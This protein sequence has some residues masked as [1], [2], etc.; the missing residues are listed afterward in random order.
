MNTETLESY[1]NNRTG[2][3]IRAEWLH[4]F[5]SGGAVTLAWLI[6]KFEFVLRHE[7][8][9]NDKE[10]FMTQKELSI[11]TKT[12]ERTLYA[13]IQQLEENGVLRISKRTVP[14]KNWYSID[15]DRLNALSDEIRKDIIKGFEEYE[16]RHGK[17]IR[18]K[19]K[20]KA[21]SNRKAKTEKRDQIGEAVLSGSENSSDLVA[22]TELREI[23]KGSPFV[24]NAAQ[25][26]K[27]FRPFIIRSLTLSGSLRLPSSSI[28]T[29][30]PLRKSAAAGAATAPAQKTKVDFPVIFDLIDEAYGPEE[31]IKYFAPEAKMPE[32]VS[33]KYP[34]LSDQHL[35]DLVPVEEIWA[36]VLRNGHHV[37]EEDR[38]PADVVYQAFY[39]LREELSLEQVTIPAQFVPEKAEIIPAAEQT[40]DPAPVPVRKTIRR[41][42]KPAPTQSNLPVP[43][44]GVA[45]Q[46]DHPLMAY[47]K[48]LKKQY[49]A[50]HVP[51]SGTKE[52]QKVEA[53][54]VAL[55]NG[56]V[57]CGG[58]YDL[59]LEYCRDW[60][61]PKKARPFSMA[62][63]KRCLENFAKAHDPA[64][65]PMN[66]KTLPRVLS[67]AL[68]SSWGGK[69]G[70]SQIL[71]YGFN[72]PVPVAQRV[73]ERAIESV[74]SPEVR[75]I[76]EQLSELLSKANGGLWEL[77]P[78]KA[79][80]IRRA[81]E[82]I[83]K[84]YDELPDDKYGILSRTFPSA[85]E[86]GRKFIRF[87]KEYPKR[88]IWNGMRPAHVGT[89][90]RAFE[91]FVHHYSTLNGINLTTGDLM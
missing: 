77:T 19:M 54:F 11:L 53:L 48:E 90:S 49:P 50:I 45:P 12:S 28:L 79:S 58:K 89:E 10:F 86:F 42:P 27:N 15:F 60:N 63:M 36:T 38:W 52:Y 87:I 41:S 25:I 33:V 35:Y 21:T 43:G 80:A 78:D 85:S 18:Q 76:A 37:R 46:A 82:S 74:Q 6:A 31:G 2:A 64:F 40:A 75:E 73:A 3:N 7:K 88:Y 30:T 13:H 47:W 26:G 20:E 70:R 9:N 69:G 84:F 61:L 72:P 39:L 65:T 4:L 5:G 66:K 44:F 32:V 67:D 59:S 56:D 57:G 83:S 17:T 68:Y 62:E 81:A 71:T 24:L 51:K 8:L 1:V 22:A 16:Y 23:I 34:T 29:N 55:R 14:C 91:G